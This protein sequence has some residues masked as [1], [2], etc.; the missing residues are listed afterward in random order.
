MSSDCCEFSHS[1]RSSRPSRQH[2]SSC[3]SMIHMGQPATGYCEM[4]KARSMLLPSTGFKA[5][6][7]NEVG[8]TIPAC[9]T[10]PRQIP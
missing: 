1:I 8:R 3:V 7:Q 2:R 10:A 6:L 9:E 4:R 5:F